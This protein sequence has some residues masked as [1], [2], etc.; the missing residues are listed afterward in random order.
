MIF[1]NRQLKKKLLSKQEKSNSEEHIQ[2]NEANLRKLFEKCSDIQ[3]QDY[4]F[5]EFPTHHVHLVYCEGMVDQKAI[6][7]V[8]LDRLEEFMEKLETYEVTKTLII[9]KLHVPSLQEV[10]SAKDIITDV[11][12]GKLLL[13]FEETKLAFSTDISK[14]PKRNPEETKLELSIKGP[15]DNFI[16]DVT[17]NIA[18]IR[19][20]LPTNSMRVES[21]QIGRRSKTKVSILYIDDIA[22]PGI[23]KEIRRLLNSIDIDGIYSGQQLMELIEKPKFIFPQHDS[24]GRPDYVV[25][26]LL[27]GRITI[28]IDGI[29]YAIITPANLF[30]LLKTAE[31][32]EYPPLYTSFTRLIRIIGILIATLFPGFWVALSAYHQ[33]QLPLVLLSKIVEGRKDIPFPVPLESFLMLI[34][35][36]LFR[37]AGLRLPSAVGQTLSVVGGLIIGDAAIRAGLTSPSMVVVI[38]TSMIATFTLVNQSFLNSVSLLRFLCLIFS[39]IFGLFGFFLSIFLVLT[40]AA[41]IRTYGIPNMEIVTRISFSNILKAMV[42]LPAPEYIRRPNMF[43]S[44]DKTRKGRE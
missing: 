19:K 28:L 36:E 15:R 22:N 5:G 32:T 9:E 33:N 1:K 26:S 11:F 16:E 27:S 43:H 41:N 42:R 39:S 31:D 37:E 13:Y 20:R 38:A 17:T 8:I 40:Y 44:K 3:F 12:S 21:F 23:V 10:P 2:I 24:T 29:T 4:Y 30:L 25:H 35:F 34:S 14:R 7:H 6:R 18:L